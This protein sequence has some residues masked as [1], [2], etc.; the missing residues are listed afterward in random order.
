VLTDQ[1]LDGSHIKGLLFNAIFDQWPELAAV[2]GFIKCFITPIVKVQP[3]RAP[4]VR[5]KARVRERLFF[6]LSEFEE[7]RRQ[8]PAGL[9]GMKARYLKGLGSSEPQEAREYFAD[10]DRFLKTYTLTDQQRCVS[11]FEHAFGNK[12]ADWRKEWLGTYEEDNVY[13]FNERALPL[14]EFVDKELKHF[15]L[16]DNQRSLGNVCDG[17]KIS[18]RKVLW[19]VRRLGLWNN[20]KKVQNLAGDVSSMSSY[21]HGE[22][23][24]MDTIVGM[25]QTF[26]GANNV[27]LLYP[28]GQFGSKL[29]NGADASD[30]RY[31]HTRL[32][33]ITR[34]IVRDADDAVLKYNVDDEGRQTEPKQFAPI[35][36]MVLV[37]GCDGIGTGYSTSVPQYNPVD[38]VDTLIGRLTGTEEK[39]PNLVPWYRNFSGSIVSSGDGIYQCTGCWERTD[40]TTIR[41]TEVPVGQSFDGYKQY[42]ESKLMD[43]APLTS[44]GGKLKA[45]NSRFFIKDYLSHTFP[46]KCDYRVIF[47][48]KDIVDEMLAD[49]TG[50]KGVLKRLKLTS[51]ISVNNMYLFTE[52]GAIRKF[53]TAADIVQYYFGVRLRLYGERKTHQ[54]EEFAKEIAAQD[55]RQRFIRLVLEGTIVV[56]RRSKTDIAGQL[57][58]HGLLDEKESDEESGE[59][60]ALLRIPL[61]AFTQEELAKLDR[62]IAA[63]RAE[64]DELEATAP[65]KIWLRELREL[66]QKLLEFMKQ[67]SLEAEEADI[68]SALASASKKPAAAAKRVKKKK[69]LMVR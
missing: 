66:R 11:E 19:G 52:E 38:V 53:T 12:F 50:P 67:S 63:L 40:D 13:D 10:L 30:P 26:V 58:E 49:P 54:L 39:A 48:T 3:T 33:E 45:A 1:D 62:K 14:E 4:T 44:D 9:R 31:I 29:A 37:N 23:S 24:L 15:S 43:N 56:F 35:I 28:S 46:S 32:S 69:N 41:V 7:F 42:L 6:N 21:H 64:R 68:A 47:P 34:L 20:T 65:E 27:N 16:Y 55:R 25:A 60:D 2:D 8:N 61:S 17:L 5:G 51:K 57:R 36:P 22:K 59:G 18:Q